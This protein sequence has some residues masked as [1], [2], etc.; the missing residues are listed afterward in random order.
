MAKSLLDYCIER[1]EFEL[2]AQWDKEKNGGLSP[3]DVSHGSHKKIWWKCAFN[4]QWEAPVYSRTGA[5]SAVRT[6]PARRHFRFQRR[7]QQ[8]FPS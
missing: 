5:G 4:P 8:G 6:V 1:D 3:R 2:L 7:W